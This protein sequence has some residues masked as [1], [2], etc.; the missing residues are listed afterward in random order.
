MKSSVTDPV[1]LAQTLIVRPS[2]TPHDEGAQDVL[3]A[4]LT[5]L[6]FTAHDVTSGNV[7][8]TFLRRGDA[9]PHFC[10]CGHT[11]VVPPGDEAG[12]R[13]PPFAGTIEGGVLYGRGASDMK[14]NIAC[15]VAALS[16][17]LQGRELKGS[18]SLLITGDEEGEATHGT[19]KVLE[20][21]QA[22][23]HVPDAALVGEPTNPGALGEEIKIGRRGSLSGTITV[24]GRQGHVA[25]PHLA[26][27]PLPKLIKLTDAL[28]KHVFDEGSEFFPPT[29]LEL[30]SIDTGNAADNV[31]P[32]KASARFNVRFN[33]R[34]SAQS[35]REKITAL[36]DATGFAYSAAFSSNAESFITAPG[37]LT[38]MVSSAVEDVTGRKPELSTKGGTSDARF[39]S[40]YCPVVEFGLINRTIHQVDECAA[41]DDLHKLTAIYLRLLEKFFG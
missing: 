27:N 17:Y 21:M 10:F 32:A 31:I 20:W 8:N 24:T 13:Y 23:G 39:V 40:R 19:V 7:R 41:V 18:V 14:G 4:A 38:D 15:F 25:Y 6:G 16:Q 35:L 30:T 1:A 37:A 34:W 9:G 12:W 33:E 29:N 22:R 5:P 26:D 28:A 36:L 11:D 3:I 2:V